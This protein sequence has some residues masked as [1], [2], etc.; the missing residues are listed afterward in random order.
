MEQKERGV[1]DDGVAACGPSRV[2][3]SCSLPRVGGLFSDGSCMFLPTL[4]P[5][6]LTHR[7]KCRPS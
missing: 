5:L 6:L 3:R 7:R 1:V 4:L 2:S